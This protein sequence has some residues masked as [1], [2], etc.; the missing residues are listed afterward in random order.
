MIR[1]GSSSGQCCVS[2]GMCAASQGLQEP[3][4]SPS[5]NENVGKLQWTISFGCS[6]TEREEAQ[7]QMVVWEPHVHGQQDHPGAIAEPHHESDAW[8][9]GHK[10]ALAGTDKFRMAVY[11]TVCADASGRG[12]HR[13]HL[14]VAVRGGV[15]ELQRVGAA[16]KLTVGDGTTCTSRR[17]QLNSRRPLVD[18]TI[19]G[20]SLFGPPLSWEDCEISRKQ[21]HKCLSRQ[22]LR[23]IKECVREPARL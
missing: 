10:E 14:R 21:I 4:A 19:L 11:S 17:K 22:D 9:Y 18:E 15:Q 1:S 23:C 5:H 7:A 3:R 2:R 20:L 16:E 6:Q 8:K 12:G 13:Q